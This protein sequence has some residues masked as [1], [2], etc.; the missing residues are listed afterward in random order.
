MT[1]APVVKRTGRTWGVFQNGQL[2]E[3]GFFGQEAARA[4]ASRI[5]EPARTDAEYERATGMP[6]RYR[7][8]GPNYNRYS[9]PDGV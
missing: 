7:F 2:V 5:I 1:Q 9:N 3:G 6:A 8:G 4:C